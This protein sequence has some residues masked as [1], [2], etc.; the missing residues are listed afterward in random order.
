[1][2]AGAYHVFSAP[3]LAPHADFPDD[4]PNWTCLGLHSTHRRTHWPF[5]R[6]GK[7]EWIDAA[8]VHWT[9]DVDALIALA[10]GGVGVVM[11]PDFL[12][13]EE[14]ASGRL[15]RRTSSDCVVPADVFAT[16]GFQEPSARARALVDH[17]VAGLTA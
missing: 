8:P 1:M 16:F 12:V 13:Q 11:L 17:L 2:L 7:L 10:V 4:L 9:D 5:A 15:L 3:D 14:V 6:Q